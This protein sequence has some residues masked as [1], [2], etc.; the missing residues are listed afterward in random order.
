MARPGSVV[1]APHRVQGHARASCADRAVSAATT[2]RA[3]GPVSAEEYLRQKRRNSAKAAAQATES[4]DEVVSDGLAARAERPELARVEKGTAAPRPET[5][6]GMASNM[7]RDS[8]SNATAATRWK[9]ILEPSSARAASTRPSSRPAM[10]AFQRAVPQRDTSSLSEAEQ[11]RLLAKEAKAR[12]DARNGVANAFLRDCGYTVNETRRT[13]DMGESDD[14]DDE[15]ADGEALDDD[16]E[17]EESEEEES[18]ED[19]EGEESDEDED[20]EGGE[21]AMA[22]HAA[23]SLREEE[24]WLSRL[25]RS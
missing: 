10:G 13:D 18:D 5:L 8:P 19:E 20:E 12:V 24:A 3:H 6:P 9:E 15:E 11:A 22:A 1:G 4:M 25:S 14:E 21:R 2:K 16:D 7:A 23:W 17:E